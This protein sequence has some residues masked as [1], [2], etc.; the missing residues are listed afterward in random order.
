MSIT[1]EAVRAAWEN[2]SNIDEACASLEMMMDADQELHRAVM[3]PHVKSAI[4]SL[5]NGSK[6]SD[7]KTIWDRSAKRSEKQVEKQVEKQA[8]WQRPF[9]PDSRVRALAEVNS[10]TIL[11]MRLRSGKRLADATVGDVI[12]ER[13]Y[14][15][16]MANH[17]GEKA[18]FF[19]KVV[20]RM[21]KS[22][23]NTVAEAFKLSDL[24]AIRVA[25]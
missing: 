21:E 7:R 12:S 8:A 4:R 18:N 15:S 24:E 3:L 11:D 16:E 9:A 5:V 6:N 14:Y 20:E 19:A 25:A 10:L 13:D 23:K 2:S 22:K 1:S 17:M